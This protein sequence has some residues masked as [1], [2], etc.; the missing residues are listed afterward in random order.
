MPANGP[1]PPLV[2]GGDTRQIGLREH[3][4]RALDDQVWTAT[5]FESAIA[6]PLK[7]T[8]RAAVVDTDLRRAWGYGCRLARLPHLL[9]VAVIARRSRTAH[10][11]FR[12]A[13]NAPKVP[14][15]PLF[16]AGVP[17]ALWLVDL[18]QCPGWW[19]RA[20]RYPCLS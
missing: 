16:E 8:P 19:R 4:L 5:G 15:I 17:N 6:M 12:D 7:I 11:A 2:A 13:W 14:G 9:A 18:D 20:D 3:D 10:I 1:L